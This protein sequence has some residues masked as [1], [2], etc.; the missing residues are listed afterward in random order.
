MH[1][2]NKRYKNLVYN[3]LVFK[4]AFNFYSQNN[5]NSNLYYY[6]KKLYK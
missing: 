2:I 6:L 5:F 1:Y 4:I 3:I